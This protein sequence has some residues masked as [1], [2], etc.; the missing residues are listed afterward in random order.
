[1][2]KLSVQ[3]MML[4]YDKQLQNA[5][6]IQQKIIP[7]TNSFKSPYYSFY[8][9]L[10]PFRRVGG[11]F[12]D[13]HIFDDNCVSL[14]L[15]DATGHGIDAAML[16][17]MVKL[18]YSYSL[19]SDIIQRSP[20]LLLKR[21]NQEIE[22]LL[23]FS[24]FSSMSILLNP[25]DSKI[26]WNNAG[27]P[28]GFIVKDGKYLRKL[29]AVLPLIGMHSMINIEEYKDLVNNFE[30][31]DKLILY[32]DGLTDGKNIQ[33][34]EYGV[35]RIQKILETYSDSSIDTL[36]KIIINDNLEFTEG[37]EASDDICLLGIQYDK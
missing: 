26:Y 28:P 3:E 31:G 8:S 6:K 37:N 11:D 20:G 19:R 16:T 23:G 1:M 34:E 22:T 32:T 9:Y 14:I 12:Y 29:E 5:Q 15:A 35:D 33:G 13:F 10:K 30:P 7:D 25:N 4:I 17:G 27:H 21:I 18:I 24:F 2:D 36:C